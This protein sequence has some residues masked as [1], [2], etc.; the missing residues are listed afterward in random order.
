MIKKSIILPAL[1]GVGLL[2][3]APETSTIPAETVCQVQK[4]S[5]QAGESLTYKVYY[6]AGPMWVSAGE[7]YFKLHDI[8]YQGKKNALWCI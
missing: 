4:E 1:L 8:N 6:N 3:S 5:F 7:I 2:T